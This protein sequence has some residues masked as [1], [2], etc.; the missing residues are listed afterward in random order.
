M[1]FRQFWN[2][3]GK[4]REVLD[5]TNQFVPAQSNLTIYNNSRLYINLEGCVNTL[6]GE[7]M[8]F[9]QS[10]GGDGKNQTAQSRYPCFY[11]KV[12]ICWFFCS[13]K[14]RMFFFLEQ[15]FHGYSSI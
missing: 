3:T 1:T 15:F 9:L 10:H 6:K 7:C 11:N 5:K 4:W 14:T 8:D 2:L 13:N 12:A